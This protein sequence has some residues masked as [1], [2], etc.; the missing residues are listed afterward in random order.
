MR[1]RHSTHGHINNHVP[2]DSN[3]ETPLLKV[4]RS[5]VGEI[6]LGKFAW[7]VME[8]MERVEVVRI[9]TYLRDRGARVYVRAHRH[10]RGYGRLRHAH[11][12]AG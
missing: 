8:H 6:S 11:V 7:A 4:S 1:L 3:R 10:D 5:V 9:N 12:S 2:T